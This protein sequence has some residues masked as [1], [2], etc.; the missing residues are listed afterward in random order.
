[1]KETPP[2]SL[3]IRDHRSYLQATVIGE[4]NASNAL[5]FPE[6]MKFAETVAM[7]RGVNVRLFHD[8]ETADAWLS[9]PSP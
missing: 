3:I 2:Y 9:A 8:L 4:H 5:R 1:M 6:K 7:N